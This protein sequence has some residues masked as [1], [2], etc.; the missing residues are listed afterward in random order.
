MG[1]FLEKHN[2]PKLTQE[3]I[4]NLNR[5]ISVEDIDSIINNLPKQKAPGPDGFTSEF[6]QIFREK[7]TTILHSLFQ[8]IEA[9]EILSN[10]FYEAN[11]T[12]I[13]KPD[14]GIIRKKLQT[15]IFHEHMCKNSQQNISKLKSTMYKKNDTTH[16]VRFIPGMQSW[17]QH[18]KIPWCNSS[19]Q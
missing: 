16:Q 1:Q 8:K 17:L 10:S 9:E 4:D 3:E 18:L 5:T 6:Y 13:S 19:H 15:N 14:K 2:L 11:I 12:L 7:I